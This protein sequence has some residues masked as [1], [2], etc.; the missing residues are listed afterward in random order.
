MTDARMVIKQATLM[1]EGGF[2]R[3]LNQRVMDWKGMSPLGL[4]KL[5]LHTTVAVAYDANK[6]QVSHMLIRGQVLTLNNYYSLKR[7]YLRVPFS[8]VQK[9]TG[10]R[11]K[12]MAS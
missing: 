7:I 6:S 3:D 9:S 12:H 11:R 2:I 1:I 10:T 5:L 4:G 8:F